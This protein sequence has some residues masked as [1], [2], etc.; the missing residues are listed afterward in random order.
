[1]NFQKKEDNKPDMDNQ[2]NYKLQVLSLE[3]SDMDFELINEQLISAGLEFEISHV[4]TE[5][6]FTTAIR[7]NIYDII[8]ADYMLP[9]FDAFRAL[10]LCQEYCPDV[11][12][13]CVSGSIGEMKAIELLK[14]GAVDYVIKDR[15]ERLPF[16]FSRALEEARVKLENKKAQIALHKSEERLRDILFST[17][18]WVWEIDEHYRYTYSSQHDIDL[19]NVAPNEIIGKTPFDFMLADEAKRVEV[20]INEIIAKKEQII[21]LENWN[22]GK[23]GQMICLLTNGVPIF[24]KEGQLRG[25]RG[26]GK[27]ITERKNAEQELII[28]KEKA[29]ASDRLKT[30]FMNNISHEVRTPLNGIL[31]F[32]Q[33]IADPYFPA[34]EKE[35]FYKMLEISSDRLLNTITSIMDISLLTS[36]NQ[37]AFKSEFPINK[38]INEIT[39]KFRNP[40]EVKNLK[41]LIK[42]DNIEKDLIIN[43]D[44]ILIGKILSHL[45]DNAIKFTTSGVVTIGYKKKENELVLYVEDS[46]IGISDK[47]KNQ[48]F[49]NFMQV[50]NANTRR[51]EGSGIGLSISKKI[52]ELLGGHIWFDSERG[53]GST[54]YIS[55][56]LK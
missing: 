12:F 51:Y 56:P 11:P 21:D 52:T 29:E 54:F 44:E 16:A 1:M 3:D 47:Y 27:N 20:I 14:N 46:G 38:L 33:I 48:I 32:G 50:D 24:D 49:D 31:G 19:F 37:K 34:E 28:A 9:Q 53:K 40:C 15:M 25:Y 26:I 35:S 43:S 17:A 7:N 13:I 45:T 4:E 2:I 18:D 41:L 36:G 22:I 30:A 39:D 8:L 23:D 55:L 5:I 6:E 42:K 10:K